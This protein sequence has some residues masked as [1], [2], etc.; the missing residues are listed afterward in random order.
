MSSL[1]S[2]LVPACTPSALLDFA[3]PIWKADMSVRMEDAYKW[4]YQATRGG[5]HAVSDKDSARK[6]LETEWQTL[7]K[8]LDNE[9]EWEPLCP[10]GEIG[11]LNLRPFRALGGN[12]DDLLSAFLFSSH[13]YCPD[14]TEFAAAWKEFGARLKKHSI[15][16]LAH[17][18]WGELNRTMKGQNYPAIHH[19]TSYG[20][21][22][23]PAYRVLTR[24]SMK[25][26]VNK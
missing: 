23:H 5:E 25:K 15:Y 7:D 20:Q 11:R 14:A 22:R 2:V 8:P 21:A 13:E 19:S 4:L 10:G 17:E 18:A 3:V 24:S 26:L 1:A 9:L 16:G 6:W 12:Q